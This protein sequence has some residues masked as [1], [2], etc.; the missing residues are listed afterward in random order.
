M[1]SGMESQNNEVIMLPMSHHV[2]WLYAT[3]V[4]Y[5]DHLGINA[6]IAKVRSVFWIV[7]IEKMMKS[8]RFNCVIC[9]RNYNKLQ[10]QVMS[11]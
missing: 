4:H 9:R 5:T 2:S 3:H 10:K 7:G 11:Q 8:I 6:D 1:N